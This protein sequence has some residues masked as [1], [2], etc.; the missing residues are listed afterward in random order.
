MTTL[1]DDMLTLWNLRTAVRDHRTAMRD[2]RTAVRDLRTAVHDLRT[3]VR[4]LR[5]AVRHFGR[6]GESLDVRSALDG[7]RQ[8]FTNGEKTKC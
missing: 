8:Q 2:V 3:A 7:D 4:D 5:T 1:H 6:A